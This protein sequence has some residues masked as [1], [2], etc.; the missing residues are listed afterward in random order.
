M[1]L[2]PGTCRFPVVMESSEFTVLIR[3]HGLPID[4]HWH[5]RNGS[6]CGP[7]WDIE[8]Q[9]LVDRLELRNLGRGGQEIRLVKDRRGTEEGMSIPMELADEATHNESPMV[10]E[11]IVIRRYE[12]GDAL[13][14][15]QLAYDVY[16]YS[17]AYDALYD[18]EGFE[19]LNAEH[20][21]V[22]MVAASESGEI[23]GHA[24][25]VM[26]ESLPGLGDLAMVMTSIRFRGRSVASNSRR[27][28][29][30]SP[31]KSVSTGC[32]WNR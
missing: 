14:I 16:G 7:W 20:K 17:Y 2:I 29:S 11:E 10:D 23:A 27:K 9:Y 4:L 13:R 18:P 21:V 32:T 3:N 28:P 22:S 6:A 31:P 15:A 26:S 30:K 8:H 19:Q 12:P 5:P 1:Q 25:I 24:A